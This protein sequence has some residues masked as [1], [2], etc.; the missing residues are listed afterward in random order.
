MNEC[1]CETCNLS[2]TPQPNPSDA[3]VLL[4]ALIARFLSSWVSRSSPPACFRGTTCT[5]GMYGLLW[6]GTWRLALW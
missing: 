5:S 2:F 4:L 1:A 6:T 3:L